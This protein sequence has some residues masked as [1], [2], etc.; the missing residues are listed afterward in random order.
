M[1]RDKIANL[2]ALR[3]HMPELAIHC[4]VDGAT[5]RHRSYSRRPRGSAAADRQ[6]ERRG[7]TF[8]MNCLVAQ[9][10]ADIVIS[11]R[12][13]RHDAARRHSAAAALFR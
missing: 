1:I 5:G 7:K 2:R 3:A 6:P 9:T 12:R 10:D 4:F 13:Q 8:G 11:H